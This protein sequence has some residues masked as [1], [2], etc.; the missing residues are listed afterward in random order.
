MHKYRNLLKDLKF[1]I[2]K[3][4]YIV[5]VQFHG[6][7]LHGMMASHHFLLFSLIIYHINSINVD[8]VSF[9]IIFVNYILDK[10]NH[11]YACNNKINYIGPIK[12]S[13][14]ARL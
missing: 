14:N 10:F 7:N 12:Y 11:L 8:I 1:Y 6:K 13:F 2:I 3:A 4:I 5:G 9:F